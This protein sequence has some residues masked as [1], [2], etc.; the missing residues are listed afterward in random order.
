MS[1]QHDFRKLH[2]LPLSEHN[3]YDTEAYT[4][5]FRA[6]LSVA[7]ATSELKRMCFFGYCVRANGP[8]SITFVEH[9]HDSF[10]ASQPLGPPDSYSATT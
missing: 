4:D 1:T 3:K 10:A 8:P 7:S 5:A 9:S 6:R 2:N